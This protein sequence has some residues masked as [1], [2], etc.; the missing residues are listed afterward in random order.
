MHQTSLYPLDAPIKDRPICTKLQRKKTMSA[1]TQAAIQSIE[2]YQR[3]LS[4][5]KG[6]CC[7]HRVLHNGQSCSEFAKQAIRTTDSLFSAL[8]YISERLTDCRKAF[9]VLSALSEEQE[10]SKRD[11]NIQPRSSNQTDTCVNIC[12]LPCL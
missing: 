8:P 5:Y 4:P 6:F 9:Q 11:S 7:S 1:T 12:T 10:E 3:Y 2:Y